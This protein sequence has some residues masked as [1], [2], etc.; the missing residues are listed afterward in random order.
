[1]YP[2]R[3]LRADLPGQAITDSFDVES[4]ADALIELN[5]RYSRELPVVE[6]KAAPLP[7][8]EARRRALGF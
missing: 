4:G 6:D 3:R 7:T 5:R 2:L 1:M 8:A